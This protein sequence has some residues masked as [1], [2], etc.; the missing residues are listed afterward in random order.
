ME[1]IPT[2]TLSDMDQLPP[3]P[4]QEHPAPPAEPEG[5]RSAT[6][7]HV[8]EKWAS[9]REQQQTSHTKH[10]STSIMASSINPP[11]S[12]AFPSLCFI[13]RRSWNDILERGLLAQAAPS[14]KSN[15]H[16]SNPPT[17]KG[18]SSSSSAFPSVLSILQAHALKQQLESFQDS[19]NNSE[20]HVD[21]ILSLLPSTCHDFLQAIG[22]TSQNRSRAFLLLDLAAIVKTHVAW[23]KHIKSPKVQFVYSLK[24]NANPT[25]LHVLKRLNV[26]LKVSNKYDLD[27]V[28]RL[29]PKQQQQSTESTTTSTLLDDFSCPAKP[30][31]F[32]RKLVLDQKVTTVAVDGPHEVGRL[33][34]A[35]ERMAS[36][37]QSQQQPQDDSFPTE[38]PQE[39]TNGLPPMN[40]VLRLEKIDDNK[41][42]NNN[43]NHTSSPYSSSSLVTHWK[44]LLQQ[45]HQA[46][47]SSSSANHHLTLVGM[48]LDL[49]SDEHQL[50]PFLE[51]V[52]ELLAFF[53]LLVNQD[54]QRLDLTGL[55]NTTE[56]PQRLVEWMA[57][58]TAPS[59]TSS[60]T[61]LQQITLDVSYLLVSKSGALCT[62][63]IGVKQNRDDHMHYYID[64]GCYGSLYAQ[65]KEDLI[66]LPLQRH[67]TP[68]TTTTTTDNTTAAPVEAVVLKATVWGP[69]CDGLDKV[70]HDILLPKLA[71]DD[72]LVFP[73]LGFCNV[74]TAFNGFSPPD[75]AYCVL[76]YFNTAKPALSSSSASSKVAAS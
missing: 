62:R 9:R 60:T 53:P 39:E 55:R 16:N 61:T 19:N 3:S 12:N 57:S 25:L 30:N 59:S 13:L 27:V 32:Y 68:T 11:A 35:L 10:A 18:T 73:N 75:T 50:E 36:R 69:T 41:M 74:G 67:P 26:S 4:E 65:E 33:V 76:G 56:I 42:D 64:D 14:K 38:Q 70:C 45:T 63:I 20:E 34:D 49:P 72:W 28:C 43:N 47:C 2:A 17:K 15:H 46:T 21:N 23:R 48:S 40:F 54:C 37:R 8:A 24:H 52:D 58:K 31:S 22:N 66:P 51:R 5:R 1:V 29:Y 6:R 7:Q 71:R 44:T